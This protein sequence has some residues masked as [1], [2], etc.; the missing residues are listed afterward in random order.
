MR[1]CLDGRTIRPVLDSDPLL[2]PYVDGKYRLEGSKAMM[3]TIRE[4][5]GH[6][7][8]ISGTTQISTATSTKAG[9]EK[10]VG[11]GRVY[12]GAGHDTSP[13]QAPDAED[14]TIDVSSLTHIKAVCR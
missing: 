9:A 6:E 11:R 12:V 13:G 7:D 5:D 1:G 4:H 3:A 10:K 8:E 14:L 2:T